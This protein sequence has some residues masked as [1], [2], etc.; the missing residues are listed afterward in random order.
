MAYLL[1][2][3]KIRTGNS[4]AGMAKID[5]L[6]KDIVS[7]KIPLMFDSEGTFLQGA[8]PVSVYSNYESDERG[9]YDLTIFAAKSDFFAEMEGKVAHGEY[10]KYDESGETIAACADKA[11]NKV[12][13]DKAS[14]AIERAFTQDFE[15]TVPPE[16]TKDGK[17]HCYLYIA[18]K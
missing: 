14:G 17:A 10:V 11:W 8:S 6:W 7:G 18:V 1:K 3:V 9:E 5:E 13:Q 12:W 15:S 4:E 2:S 16:Y